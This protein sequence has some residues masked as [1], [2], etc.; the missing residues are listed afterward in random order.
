MWIT[1]GVRKGAPAISRNSESSSESLADPASG[2]DPAEDGPTVV[3]NRS[4][5]LFTLDDLEVAREVPVGD[6]LAKLAVLPVA[7]GRVVLDEGCAE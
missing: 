2:S 5:E 6:V 7:R 1:G 4:E 3:E